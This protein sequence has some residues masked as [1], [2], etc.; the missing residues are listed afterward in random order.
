MRKRVFPLDFALR[1]PTL[2]RLIEVPYNDMMLDE[3]AVREA[4]PRGVAFYIKVLRAY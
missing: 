4:I 3:A 2:K 1:E